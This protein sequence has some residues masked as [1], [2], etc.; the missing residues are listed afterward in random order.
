MSYG[1]L[2]IWQ[3]GW[4]ADK[5]VPNL[6]IFKNCMYWMKYLTFAM[7]TKVQCYSRINTF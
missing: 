5:I 2:A 4:L 1:R 6:E 7:L 3:A